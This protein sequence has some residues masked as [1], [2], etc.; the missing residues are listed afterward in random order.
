MKNQVELY[1]ERLKLFKEYGYDIP[2]SRKFILTK[3]KVSGGRI[4]E[5]GTGRGHMAV[6]LAKNGLKVV[7]RTAVYKYL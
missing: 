2:K 4:L 3:A 5:V 7:S 1:N 6:A